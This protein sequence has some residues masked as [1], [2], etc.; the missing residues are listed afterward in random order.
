M[1]TYTDKQKI[2]RKHTIQVKER[3][4]ILD[5]QAPASPAGRLVYHPRAF[6]KPLSCQAGKHQW[7]NKVVMGVPFLYCKKCG[8]GC[9]KDVYHDVLTPRELRSNVPDPIKNIHKVDVID[10]MVEIINAK[11]RK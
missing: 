3:L 4:G 11:S 10:E 1:P 5:S 7:E 6:S 9:P 2:Q 8:A